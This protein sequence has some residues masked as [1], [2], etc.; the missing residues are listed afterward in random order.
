MFRYLSQPSGSPSASEVHLTINDREISV[1]AG[2][3]VWAA[4]AQAGETITRL[5]PVTEQ[6]RSAYCAMGVCFEC[7]VEI[8]GMP[9]RQ[10]CLTQVQDGMSVKRQKITQTSE[11]VATQSSDS[12][13]AVQYQEGQ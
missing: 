6:E 10:A 3:S 4:M 5:S 2:T 11:A 7:L 8:D 12:N 9:N 1:P 13:S